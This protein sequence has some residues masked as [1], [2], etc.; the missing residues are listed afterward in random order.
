MLPNFTEDANLDKIAIIASDMDCT[1]LADDG[2]MPPHMADR[3]RE[4]DA[5]GITFCAASGRPNYTLAEMFPGLDRHMALMSDNG[6]AIYCRGELI[7]ESLIPV[8]EYQ[9]MIRYTLDDGRGCPTVCGIDACYIRSC[10]ERYDEYFRTF[11]KKIV[12]MD[13]LTTLDRD[14]NKYTVFFPGNDSEEVYRETYRD[15]W[16][17]RYTV[18][19]AGKMWIDMMNPGVDKGS[20]LAR[21]CEHLGVDIKDACALGDTYNDVQMLEE[22]GHGYVVANAEE[23]MHEHAGWL[24]PSNNDRGVAAVIDAVLAA[25]A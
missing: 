5:A 13:D 23:H 12:Y 11:Y 8:D 16:S 6:A 25:R 3:I 18:T 4:L 24:A 19:N 20:G 15:A 10:D 1:L 14:V 7:Y 22:A 17:D 21:L 2:T 9:R